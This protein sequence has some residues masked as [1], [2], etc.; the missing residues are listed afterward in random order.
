MAPQDRKDLKGG[1]EDKRNKG[2]EL[3]M[4]ETGGGGTPLSSPANLFQIFLKYMP[5]LINRWQIDPR[6]QMRQKYINPLKPVR[7]KISS[8]RMALI[9]LCLVR[10]PETRT[11]HLQFS[12]HIGVS[13]YTYLKEL[14]N[15]IF[16]H[17]FHISY[18]QLF[19][20]DYILK[21]DCRVFRINIDY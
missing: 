3:E 19:S 11:I 12:L 14:W 6:R 4:E 21:K 15:K 9:I 8:N 17:F 2:R 7:N 18:G 10:Q 16:T 13:L 20:I 5:I 1:T